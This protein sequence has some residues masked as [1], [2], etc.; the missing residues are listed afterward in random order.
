MKTKKNILVR[1]ELNSLTNG[2]W[3]VF[4][5][6]KE[7]LGRPCDVLLVPDHQVRDL[8]SEQ[9][10]FRRYVRLAHGRSNGPPPGP[11][12]FYFL[13]GVGDA[14]PKEMGVYLSGNERIEKYFLD[15]FYPNIRVI[16]DPAEIGSLLLDEKIEGLLVPVGLEASIRHE[17][18]SFERKRWIDER[19]HTAMQVW[20]RPDLETDVEII[21]DQLEKSRVKELLEVREWIVTSPEYHRD[22]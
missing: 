12:A 19:T 13:P 17:L 9:S 15:N 8:V 16:R 5:N 1:T 7:A 22:H 14:L 4:P 20:V 6:Q 18:V 3:H 2:D 11:L 21:M 10:V